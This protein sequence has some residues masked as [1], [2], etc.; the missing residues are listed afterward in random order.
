MEQCEQAAFSYSKTKRNEYEAVWMG[1]IFLIKN[2]EKWLRSSMNGQHFR[3]QRQRETRTKQCEQAAFSSSKTKRNE[4]E[5][6]WMGSIFLFKNKE[7]RI[8]SSM[9]GQHFPHQRQR[10]T[11]TKQCE[12]A[13]FSSSKTK[14]NEYRA[15]WIGSIFIIKD[16]EKR[17]QSSMNGQHFPHQKRRLMNTEQCERSLNCVFEFHPT[18]MYLWQTMLIGDFMWIRYNII[19]KLPHKKYEATRT[20]DSYRKYID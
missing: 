12:W 8:Q 13:A 16:K 6:V 9:N 10:E 7:K 19:S 20:L 15:V 18:R 2:K 5:V 4:Y 14:R 11:R 17:I 3:H 1:S